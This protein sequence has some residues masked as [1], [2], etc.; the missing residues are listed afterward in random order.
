[1]NKA[2]KKNKKSWRKNVDMT[3]VNQHLE[4]ERF[5][6]RVG[7]SFAAR[8]NDVLFTIEK[9]AKAVPEKRNRKEVKKLL[10]LEN[11]EKFCEHG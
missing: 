7:G 5:E 10:C 4:E 9:D 8:S 3:A 1:M 6:E 2:S 11:N